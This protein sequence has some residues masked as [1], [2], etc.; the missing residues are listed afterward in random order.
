MPSAFPQPGSEVED[1]LMGD[2][3]YL[4]NNSKSAVAAIIVVALIMA[5]VILMA[6]R[7]APTPCEKWNGELINVAMNVGHSRDAVAAF[8]DH[9]GTFQIRGSLAE[10]ES[11]MRTLLAE[12]PD[13]CEMDDAVEK[14]VRK[15]TDL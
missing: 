13:D 8:E 7:A 6:A 14:E 11:E 10:S 15:V 9:P 12:P 4:R 2:P 3:G 1:D 5:G